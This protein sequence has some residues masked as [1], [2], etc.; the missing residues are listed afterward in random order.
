MTFQRGQFVRHPKCP[1]WGIGEVLSQEGDTVHV[2]FQQVGKK[3]LITRFVNLQ[4]AEAEAS[5]RIEWAGVRAQSN[6][7]IGKLEAICLQFHE[8]MKDNRSNTDDGGMGL[9]VLHDMKERGDLTRTT[10]RQLLAWCHTEGP[11][12]QQGVG[13]AQNICREIYGRVPTRG[14]VE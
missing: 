3:K 10:R 2:L 9:N 13:L 7:D 14:E 12:Y 11:V 4:L 6:V 5:F 1:D 8:E